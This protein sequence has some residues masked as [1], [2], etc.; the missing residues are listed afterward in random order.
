LDPFAETWEQIRQLLTAERE[1]RPKTLFE[2]LQRTY[3]ARFQDGQVRP[4][5]HRIKFWRATE[6][7]PRE[8]FF[9][10]E[11]RPGVNQTSHIA[12]SWASQSTGKHFRI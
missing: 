2:H 9:A 1:L 8:V 6:G 3:P 5:R 12:G 11:H 10:Q 4:L 7:P